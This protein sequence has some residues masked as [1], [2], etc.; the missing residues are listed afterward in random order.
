ME[1][2]EEEAV[3]S[4]SVFTTPYNPNQS[5][6]LS[7]PITKFVICFLPYFFSFHFYG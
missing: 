4:S 7:Q 3:K 5:L 6:N 1:R 2:I